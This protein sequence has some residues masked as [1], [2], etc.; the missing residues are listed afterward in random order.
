MRSLAETETGSNFK[1]GAALFLSSTNREGTR[2]IPT[3]AHHLALRHRLYQQHL[4]RVNAR[5][6]TQASID[7]QFELLIVGP[8][9]ALAQSPGSD[10]TLVVLLDGIGNC[11]SPDVLFNLLRAI[12]KSPRLPLVWIITVNSTISPPL[13]D[14]GA[15]NTYP[16]MAVGLDEADVVS[17][18]QTKF[19]EIKTT[20]PALTQIPEWP[21]QLTFEGVVGDVL[22]SGIFSRATEIVQYV[23]E[24]KGDPTQILDSKDH[25][26]VDSTHNLH[27]P[28]S[29]L[30]GRKSPET[31]K[32]LLLPFLLPRFMFISFF[33]TCNWLGL[34]GRDAYAAIAPLDKIL[35][36]PL[37][38]SALSSPIFPVHLHFFGYLKSSGYIDKTFIEDASRY[39][40]TRILRE[41]HHS[42][43]RLIKTSRI[44]LAWDVKDEQINQRSRDQLFELSLGW[45]L[46]TD[47]DT[48]N[49]QPPSDGYLD[50][51][52]FFTDVD[53]RMHIKIFGSRE[54]LMFNDRFLTHIQR[55][56]SGFEVSLESLNLEHVLWDQEA[57][58]FD[59]QRVVKAPPK[60]DYDGPFR[61]VTYQLQVLVI[62]YPTKDTPGYSH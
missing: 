25:A 11:G 35:Y 18:L 8:F 55:W 48:I 39:A 5:N 49:G 42:T 30:I 7:K 26:P 21:N 4:R 47:L 50:L 28:I 27:H 24:S 62:D 17:Y 52:S 13:P 29:A 41:S 9:S 22:K 44:K 56:G 1:L 12:N 51:Q 57:C 10:E 14:G 61:W 23:A 20:K 2:I 38:S 34:S 46:S 3:I 6:L 15:Q 40:Y 60:E 19:N 16:E 37:P 32:K 31:V 33:L 58:S 53:Y 45:L 54:I 59:M 43:D 36:I